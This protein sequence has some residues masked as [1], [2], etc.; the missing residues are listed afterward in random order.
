MFYEAY[1]YETHASE[2]H[3]G[4]MH[5]HEGFCEDLARQNAVA[6]LSQLQ[7]RFRRRHIWVSDITGVVLRT[8]I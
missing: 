4:K 1:A 8:T 6:R 3:T 5:A 7:V 2:I